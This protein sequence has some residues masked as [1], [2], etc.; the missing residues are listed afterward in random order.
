LAVWAWSRIICFMIEKKL[1]K[2]RLGEHL[3]IRQ[4]LEYWL[5]RAPEERLA[6]VDLLRRQLYGNTKRLQRTSRIVQRSKG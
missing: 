3:E 1:H 2:H 6:A 4:N 5:S